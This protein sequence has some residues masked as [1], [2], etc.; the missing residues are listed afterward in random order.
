MSK[1]E[2][3]LRQR[4]DEPGAAYLELHGYREE[5]DSQSTSKTICV[6]DVIENY[7]GPKLNF[8]FNSEGRLIVI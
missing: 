7:L 5:F 6:F 4:P 8:D 3:R 2:I 1:D